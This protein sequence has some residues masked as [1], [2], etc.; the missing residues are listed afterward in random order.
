M[1]RRGCISLL[2]G[3]WGLV[4]LLTLTLASLLLLLRFE[5]SPTRTVPRKGDHKSPNPDSTPPVENRSSKGNGMKVDPTKPEPT[6]GGEGIKDPAL[7]PSP[8]HDPQPKAAAADINCPCP[9][10]LLELQSRPHFLKKPTDGND[11]HLVGQ[12]GSGSST[13]RSWSL[14]MRCLEYLSNYTNVRN[15]TAMLSTARFG[16]TVKMKLSYGLPPGSSCRRPIEGVA[17]LPQS[18][19]PLEP[20][21][22]YL[23]FELD[24][25]LQLNYVPPTTW[26]FLPIADVERAAL[27]SLNG[28]SAVDAAVDAK[29]ALAKDPTGLNLAGATNEEDRDNGQQSKAAGKESPEDLV[30]RPIT[31]RY[32]YS[33]WVARE[34]LMYAINHDLVVA[35]PDDGR[36]SIGAS[37]QLWIQGSRTAQGTPLQYDEA[38]PLRL[39]SGDAPGGPTSSPSTTSED[40]SDVDVEGTPDAYKR[41]QREY[42]SDTLLFDALISND[43]RGP[44]KN[45]NVFRLK[46]SD[47]DRLK[48]SYPYRYINVDQGKSLYAEG[49]PKDSVF[50]QAAKQL[51]LG[52]GDGTAGGDIHAVL[53]SSICKFRRQTVLALE[54]LVAKE[55]GRSPS[56]F[57]GRQG[58][59]SNEGESP[60]GHEL[61][62]TASAAPLLA[63]LR[64]SV[65]EPILRHIGLNRLKSLQSRLNKLVEHVHRCQA[66]FGAEKIW[67]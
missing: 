38:T 35:R 30:G 15:V 66:E 10:E 5:F 65:P 11:V 24:Q 41:Y 58:V 56:V 60:F 39:L 34:S 4:L 13:D 43:D 36:L 63:N 55:Q 28:L 48:A 16:R 27:D 46:K 23:A 54:A 64:E 61:R 21:S 33:R 37:V 31:H 14:L 22:E 1:R 42:L 32:E 45:T 8:S 49:F 53:R 26:I 3:R 18:L 6:Q 9:L 12:S 17:K 47:Y 52:V 7:K 62:V 29:K 50:D 57:G 25:M 20:Y 44:I 51:A 2:G 59:G 40:V 67:L 19:F